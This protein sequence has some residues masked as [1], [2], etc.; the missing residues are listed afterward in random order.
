[1]NNIEKFSYN[2]GVKLAKEVLPKCTELNYKEV[3]KET[4]YSMRMDSIE[5]C[6]F[7]FSFAAWFDGFIDFMRKHYED[8]PYSLYRR[9]LGF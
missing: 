6:G 4:M 3:I 9:G 5:T 1:M 7:T 8:V 2:E